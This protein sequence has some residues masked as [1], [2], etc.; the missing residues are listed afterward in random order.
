MW[1]GVKRNQLRMVE[2]L[3]TRNNKKLLWILNLK[4]KEWEKGWEENLRHSW[5]LVKTYSCWRFSDGV[6]SL[7]RGEQPLQNHIR[8]RKESRNQYLNFFSS[9]FRPP[10]P[11]RGFHWLNAKLV[12]DQGCFD[13]V[14]K[15]QPF[16][17]QK[18]KWTE[19]ANR[20]SNFLWK[21]LELWKR[22]ENWPHDPKN[23]SASVLVD[24]ET[25]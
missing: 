10:T 14:H 6:C 16:E 11:T 25:E 17:A 8:A 2:H 22:G 15:G 19:E 7:D 13:T 23:I 5:N 12:Q 3:S 24:N 18:V 20:V 9:A 1:A 4:Q 21:R